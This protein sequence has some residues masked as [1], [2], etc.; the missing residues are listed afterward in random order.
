MKA[1]DLRIGNL[2]LNGADCEFKVNHQTIGNFYSAQILGSF[3]PIPLTEEWLEKLGFIWC[4]LRNGWIIEISKSNT[5]LIDGRGNVF[6]G[7][8]V[9]L[10]NPILEVHQLQN[11]YFALTGEELK[12]KNK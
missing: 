12:I 9:E 6:I 8:D 10:D 4:D 11:L 2:I 5:L 7:D 3:K 1:S